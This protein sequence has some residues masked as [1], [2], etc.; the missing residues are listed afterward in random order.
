MYASK[1]VR[2]CHDIGYTNIMS[3]ERGVRCWELPNKNLGHPKVF[4][5]LLTKLRLLARTWYLFN[6]LVTSAAGSVLAA[7]S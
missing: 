5:E 2:N 3:Q 4:V 6:L 7:K 1:F